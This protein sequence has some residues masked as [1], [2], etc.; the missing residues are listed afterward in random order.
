MKGKIALFVYV[1]FGIV[2]ISALLGAWALYNT[3]TNETNGT[4]LLTI[5]GVSVI[6]LILAL[7]LFN[8]NFTKIVSK[9]ARDVS[10]SQRESMYNFPAP[11]FIINNDNCI[12]WTNM[13][14]DRYV[15]NNIDPYG[16]NV[17]DLFEYNI[18][19]ISSENGEVIHLNDRFYRIKALVNKLENEETITMIYFTD[20]TS[21][22]ELQY[23]YKESRPTVIWITIDNYDELLQNAKESEKSK[24]VV[25]IERLIENF[26]EST[27][28]ISRKISSDRFMIVVEERHLNQMINSKFSILDKAR[29]I[30]VDE[31]RSVTLSIGIGHCASNLVESE[32]FARQALDM[33]LGRG[34]DQVAIKTETGFEFYGG[35]SNGLEKQTKVKTRMIA[36]ALLELISDNSTVYIM[37]HKQGDM[38]SVGSA[39]GLCAAIRSMGNEAY[40][41]VDLERNLAKPLINYIKENDKTEFYI[42]PSQALMRIED[43]SVVIIVDTHN[44]KIV[45]SYEVYR[46]AKKVV[47][48]DHH[49]KMVNHID[50]AIIFFHEPR[51]SSAS[52]MVAELIQY[53]GEKAKITIP[54]AEGLLAGIMLDTKNFVMRTGVRTFE[55]AA[56]LKQKG[57]DTVSVKRLF[58]NS[59]DTY[60]QK[61]MLITNCEIYEKCAISTARASSPSMRVAAPQAADELLGINNVEASFVLYEENGIINISARSMGAFN[62]QIIMEALGGGG[63]QTMAGAQLKSSTLTNAKA[64]IFQAIDDYLKTLPKK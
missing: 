44:P 11:A 38:D 45:D 41:V 51:A 25:E 62:V 34:G 37:G 31:R 8:I 57:A 22:V 30:K 26:T 33:C 21:F 23:E 52:E 47:V 20:I 10:N 1:M 54:Q 15:V 3:S 19:K 32:S 43:E 5:S 56:Y 59:I 63:H 14:F 12:I 48:I 42:T 61:S 50:D 16:K 55:A 35:V 9:T 18:E 29:E 64:M 49:R 27:T 4:I 46:A 39:T 40:V 24:A 60:Q 2:S 36:N 6:L 53:F 13:L 7:I 58:D 17:S 28:G